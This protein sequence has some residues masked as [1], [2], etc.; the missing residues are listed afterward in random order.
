[1]WLSAAIGIGS[2]ALCANPKEIAAPVKAPPKNNDRRNRIP[3]PSASEA[4][5]RSPA[6]TGE[7]AE[8]RRTTDQTRRETASGSNDRTD[9]AD[10]P[11]TN[12][13]GH[14]RPKTPVRPEKVDA[15]LPFDSSKPGSRD[16]P[17]LRSKITACD[18]AAAE[19]HSGRRVGR[20]SPRPADGVSIGDIAIP[21]IWEG[22]VE[23]FG[24]A[25][26]EPGQQPAPPAPVRQHTPPIAAYS[27]KDKPSSS[28]Q[29]A[30]NRSRP[31]P[32][33]QESKRRIAPVP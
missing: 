8:T 16:D 23:V 21:V 6:D 20:D 29:T 13:R 15:R 5:G 30:N 25:C 9:G 14:W 26:P 1:M 33:R 32:T 12:P 18:A 2:G 10:P 19:T 24:A 28:R 31:T 7:P 27:G 22:V 3:S 17:S 11:N 4:R